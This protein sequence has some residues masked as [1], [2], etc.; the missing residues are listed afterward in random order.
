MKNLFLA[1]SIVLC[2][3]F[4]AYA[5]AFVT[6]LDVLTQK[7]A[8]VNGDAT[9]VYYDID[10]D[11]DKDLISGTSFN[12]IFIFENVGTSES[13]DFIAPTFALLTDSNTIKSVM[14]GSTVIPEVTDWNGDNRPDLI[15]SGYQ[16]IILFTNCA[17]S[18]GVIPLFAD[19][20]AIPAFDSSTNIVIAAGNA[21]IRAVCY[22]GSSSN[23]LLI[24][25]RDGRKLKWYKNIGDYTSPVLTNMGFAKDANGSDLTFAW[26]PGPI[27]FDW[28]YD[29]TNDLIVGDISKIRVYST[30]NNPPKW[31]LTKSFVTEP[32]CAYYKLE[33][34]GDINADG[35]PDMILGTFTG[36][37]FWLTNRGV[38]KADFSTYYSVSAPANAVEFGHYAPAVNIWDANGDNLL[39]ISLRRNGSSGIR[40]YQNVGKTNTPEFDSFYIYPYDISARE[41]FYTFQSNQFMYV[42]KND[43]LIVYTNTGTYSSPRFTSFVN[44]KEGTND[45]PFNYNHSGFDISDMNDDG[46]LDLWYYYYGTNYWFENTNDNF[47]PVYKERQ[48]MTF[49][50]NP[51]AFSDSRV[52]PEITDWN[53]DGKLDILFTR[54]NGQIS[55]YENISNFPPVYVSNG[56]LETTIG[57][58]ID[59]ASAMYSFDTCDIDDNGLMDLFIG[60][61]DA[62]VHKFEAT[63]EPVGIWI[64]GLLECWVIVKRRTSNVKI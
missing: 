18:A 2:L 46:R 64:I 62:K 25:E 41:R 61:G 48:L 50:G 14:T 35:K 28:D 17:V 9:P 6:D 38:G 36:G 10:R 19:A 3:A 47:M 23:D 29:G 30:T 7:V 39:D 15:V 42:Y 27:L 44:L 33:P 11:G 56:Y 31:I 32:S 26:G 21:Y 43:L 37:L 22:D 8:S 59:T 45:I 60:F 51:F 1:L 34:C 52:V 40:I 49:D 16:Q 58:V 57:V 5:N 53:S 63:P 4:N 55:Y 54:A 20:G 12:D 24:G 13:P